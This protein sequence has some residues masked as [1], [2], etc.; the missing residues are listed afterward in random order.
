MS[1]AARTVTVRYFAAIREALG[2][3]SERV[4]TQAAT[5]RALRD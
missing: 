2:T 1:A 5:L 3:G 4:A